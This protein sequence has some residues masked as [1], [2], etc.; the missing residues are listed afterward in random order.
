MTSTLKAGLISVCAATLTACASNPSLINQIAPGMTT[1]QVTQIMG[2]PNTSAANAE[3][4]RC[5]EYKYPKSVNVVL[6]Y[7]NRVILTKSGWGGCAVEMATYNFEA[8]NGLRSG[9]AYYKYMAP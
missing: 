2:N 3:G 1:Q 8:P 5:L 7:K 4:F 6:T 9:G